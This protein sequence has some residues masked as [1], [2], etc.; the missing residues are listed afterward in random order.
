MRAFAA[1][2]SAAA[3]RAP[4]AAP[5]AKLAAAAG[6]AAAAGVAVA[7]SPAFAAP[8]TVKG[9]LEEI[10]SRLDRI[11][12]TLGIGE[13]FSKELA[14][15]KQVQASNPDNIGMA[16]F[17]FDYFDSLSPALQKR[18]IACARSGFENPDSGMGAYAIQVRRNCTHPT[19]SPPPRLCLWPLQQQSP[20]PLS[21]L[22]VRACVLTRA[23]VLRHSRTTTT[24]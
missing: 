1:A 9:L 4:R 20:L 24:C 12:D 10:G 16:C 11:E 13:D 22:C 6:G 14:L 5:W 15:I 17:D 7:A 21:A 23:A 8:A 19:A 3:R 18:M 2:R